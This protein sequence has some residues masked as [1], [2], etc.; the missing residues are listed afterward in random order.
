[1]FLIHKTSHKS[2]HQTYFCFLKYLAIYY[3]WHK[4]FIYFYS[5]FRNI[6]FILKSH[7]MKTVCFCL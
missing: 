2:K 6:Q 3:F 7:F 4:L 5:E 1:M